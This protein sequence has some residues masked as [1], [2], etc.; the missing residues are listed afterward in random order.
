[1]RQV[2]APVH[3]RPVTEE[4]L[5]R[6]DLVHVL[7]NSRRLVWDLS[8]TGVR[9]HRRSLLKWWPQHTCAVALQCGHRSYRTD[10]ERTEYAQMYLIRVAG[11]MA[12]EV[13][14]V[15]RARTATHERLRDRLVGIL[16][17]TIGVDLLCAVL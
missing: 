5:E 13:R 16:L 15:A 9:C 3:V 4:T 7:A 8:A 11:E 1:M 2:V 14:D 6:V 17:A 12:R 10:V